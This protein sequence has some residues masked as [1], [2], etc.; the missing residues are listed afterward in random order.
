MPTYNGE[1]YLEEAVGS[2]LNQSLHDLE[3]I[4]ID[5]GSKDNTGLI[6]K[7]LAE[8]DDR[9]R[10]LTRATPSGGPTIPKNQALSLILSPYVC[11]LDHDDYYHA[12]KL[13][14]MVQGMDE[15]PEWV[16]AFHDL[17]LVHSDG[18]YFSGTYLSNA[19]FMRKSSA[20]LKSIGRDWSD[21]GSGFYTFM[22]LNYAAFHTDS[23]IVC[24]Q[25]LLAD[26]V[27]FRQRFRGSDDTDL[28]L[29]IGA[30]GSIGYLNQTLAYYRQHSNNM[31]SDSL[32]MTE[33]AVEL[34][35][36]NYLHAKHFM[37]A[38][39]LKSY[40]KKIASYQ[41]TLGYF[42][43]KKNL[44]SQSIFVY[45]AAAINGM[46]MMAIKGILKSSIKQLMTHS[47]ADSV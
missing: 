14:K 16:A 28:W 22:S 41:S 18:S 21:C 40:R 33:N 2:V 8:K 1:L 17:Q 4:I 15:H 35:Q 30:Q 31:S 23:V 3:I 13:E 39:Q 42:Y 32:K 36:A 9:V 7:K 25:R 44:F 46:P 43:Y 27:S 38:Q 37:D 20:Y 24:P 6:L 12:E 34:H 29:R 5:D 10:V 19:D 47:K 26:P 11:F 45:A